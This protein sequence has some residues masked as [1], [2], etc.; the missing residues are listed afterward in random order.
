[1]VQ[2]S[3]EEALSWQLFWIKLIPLNECKSL[4]IL[5]SSKHAKSK[6]L[7]RERDGQKKKQCHANTEMEI[8]GNE[9]T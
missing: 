2:D 3:R 8:V 1:M 6:Q 9:E 7:S 4:S 5:E